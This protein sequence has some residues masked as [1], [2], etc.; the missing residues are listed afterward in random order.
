MSSSHPLE[1]FRSFRQSKERF[2]RFL[3]ALFFPFVSFWRDV[4]IFFS[5]IATRDLMIILPLLCITAGSISLLFLWAFALAVIIAISL[6]ILVTMYIYIVVAERLAAMRSR[7]D[8][9]FRSRA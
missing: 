8:Q 4:C 1:D 6:V 9:E 3:R 2:R 7:A 5:G